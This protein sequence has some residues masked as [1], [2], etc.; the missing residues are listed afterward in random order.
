MVRQTPARSARSRVTPARQPKRQRQTDD[1][2]PDVYQELLE[3]AEARDPEQFASDRPIKR[4]KAGVTK[5]I[6]VGLEASEQTHQGAEANKDSTQ[7][8]QTIYD[9]STSDESEVDWE[10]VELQQPP[11]S[12]LNKQFASQ[13]DDE[14]LQITLEQEPKKHKRAI[15]RRKPLNG[16]ERKV[17]LDVHKCHILCLLGH[18]QLR[19]MW[20]NDEELQVSVGPLAYID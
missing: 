5:A 2:T 20:C 8:V 9:S 12:L 1:H 19:N 13:G 10:D 6:P 16:A 7:A 3:E 15:Q 4:R 14:M 17:R 18:V 11:Q